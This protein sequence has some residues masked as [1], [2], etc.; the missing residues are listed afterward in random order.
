MKRLKVLHA[1][2]DYQIAGAGKYLLTLVAQPEYSC[3]VESVVCC[4]EGPLA[5][6]LRDLG[7]Q[8]LP[9][10]GRDK[11][12]SPR[13]VAAMVGV[14][15]KVRPHLVHT[16]ASL[17][18]RIAAWLCRV[19]VVF[20]K[21]TP[22]RSRARVLGVLQGLLSR[23]AIAV[24]QH[25]A[26]VLQDQGYPAHKIQVIYN[27]VDPNQFSQDKGCNGMAAGAPGAVIGTVGRLV[28]QKG[29]SV[30]VR[31]AKT[32]VER[33][34]DCRFLIAGE[35]PE[36]QNLMAL[37][38][39]L[40]LE[41]WVSFRGYVEDVP[42]FLR[43]L[44]LF[45]LP[46]LEEGLGIALVEAMMCGLPVVASRGGGIPEVIRDPSIGILVEPN[47][48]D[49]LAQ[50]MVKVLEHRQESLEMGAR[51][52]QFALEHFNAAHMA[53]RTVEFYLK[54]MGEGRRSDCQG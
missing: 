3:Q 1:I 12:F 21:H 48:P 2:P 30:L 34:P 35:G 24:S 11:S 5:A 13:A 14:I 53:Q 6:R 26:Q 25:V 54:V 32:V 23:G 52:R 17:S 16:H 4:P 15:E 19:P 36:R 49:G 44:D 10:P 41:G 39:Q 45:V 28:P 33:F 27:G 7:V 46:S 47:D 43:K 18:A 40:G 9:L 42:S 51:A 22:D 31:A 37:V 20:T 38:R 8:W 29:H 50:A